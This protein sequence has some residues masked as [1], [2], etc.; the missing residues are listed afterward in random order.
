MSSCS[1]ELKVRAQE[2][3]ELMAARTWNRRRFVTASLTGGA[4]LAVS[5]RFAPAQAL[6]ANDRIRVGVVGTGGRARGMMQRLKD[7]PGCELLVALS[8]RSCNEP[9]LLEAVEI[10]GARAAKHP[11][12]RRLLDD[13]DVDAVLA[14]PGPLARSKMT[15]DAL[16]AGKDVYL[17]KPVSH[18]LEDGVALLK[19]ASGTKQ[20]IKTGTQQRS[21]EHFILGKQ[22]VDSGKLG[23]I[24]FVHTYWHQR[25]GSGPWP[26]VDQA[27]LDWKGWLGRAPE[28]RFEPE[29]FFRWR[30]FRDFGGAC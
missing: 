2:P 4:A 23:Q 19:L 1:S 28:Q 27:K 15:E 29:R 6:G 8:E 11:D 7:L 22:L 25:M 5:P 14:A 24:T 10:A 21:W 3:G 12:Y 18:T 13:K 20:V 16:A 9:R 26:E 17:E 30:H